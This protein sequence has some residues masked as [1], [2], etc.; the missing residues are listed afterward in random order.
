[1]I[2]PSR[3]ND[4]LQ[5]KKLSNHERSG[6]Y[7]FA[8]MACVFC[9]MA[10]AGFVPSYQAAY[11]G[12]FKFHWFVHV[13]GAIMAAWFVVFLIQ[14]ILVKNGNLKLHRKLGFYSIGLGVM[15]WL[16]MGIVS[17][18]VLIGFPPHVHS[19][20][21][22]IWPALWVQ[23]SA[24]N[25]F[26][27]FFVRAVLARR[28]AAEHKRLLYLAMLV[29]LQ[30]AVGRMSW[31]PWYGME[32]PNVF[33]FYLDLLLIPLIAYDLTTTSRIHRITIIGGMS[34]IAAQLVT[35]ILF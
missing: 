20:K 14:T 21:E 24:M 12:T 34:I 6:R 13:H 33:F 17:Y 27:F 7:F 9:I 1:M 31:L 4:F 5:E 3:E 10:V 30:A 26:G 29:L 25:L 28:K 35:V 15:V 11:A 32:N 22:V 8:A 19:L 18:R 2:I 23:V 16:S